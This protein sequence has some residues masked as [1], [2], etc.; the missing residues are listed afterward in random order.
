MVPTRR[1]G[2]ISGIL[3][4]P[5]P[6]TAPASRA[7]T[8]LLVLA[9][10]VAALGFAGCAQQPEQ[11]AAAA[12]GKEYFPSSKYGPASRR[13][14]ADGQPVPRG[15]GQYL[16]GKP[17]TVAGQTYYP[18]ERHVVQV[19]KAS[20]YG[21]AF[22]GRLT[23]NGEIYDRNSFTA[24]HP[25]LPL[26]SYAR[27]TNLRNNTSMIVRVNDRGPYASNRI[28]DVSRGVAEA[29]D[30]RRTGTAMVKVEYV[31]RA[32]LAGS[33]D[34]KLLATLRTD[35]PARWQGEPTL[36]A[37]AAAP[38][39][40]VASLAP[41]APQDPVAVE[42]AG[43]PDSDYADPV[44]GSQARRHAAPSAGGRTD[45]RP[46]RGSRVTGQRREPSRDREAGARQPAPGA[47]DAQARTNPVRP[48]AARADLARLIE[49]SQAR[50]GGAEARDRPGHPR[51]A[52]RAAAT[53]PPRP[54]PARAAHAPGTAT[55]SRAAFASAGPRRA[56]P[57]HAGLRLSAA[58][59]D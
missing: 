35:G 41:Y 4:E 56:D 29:L 40:R 11:V 34:A 23:A 54:S 21:D 26:P 47:R 12:H 59:D 8:R 48:A 28:M 13:V 38:P 9:S 43:A 10:L 20:W 1:F 39:A 44:T 25:T 15:G 14:I 42:P 19:G 17:Y 50:L 18:S 33:D 7:A 32:S 22:H 30:F 16:V 45:A 53:P 3:A 24:A 55:P 49:Q 31:A 46:D 2:S 6:A 36:L 5:R 52:D 37:E 51:Q 58:R 27:V 57:R